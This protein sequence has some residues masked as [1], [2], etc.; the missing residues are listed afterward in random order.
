MNR[1][2]RLSNWPY[3]LLGAMSLVCFGGPLL[4]FVVVRGGAS[5]YWPP[6]RAVE[7]ITIALVLALFGALFLAC[8][9]IGWWSLPPR[10]GKAPP[11]R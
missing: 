3:A 1:T 9:T 6:D 2:P 11:G 7:W 5:P 8:V 10:Q 4:I